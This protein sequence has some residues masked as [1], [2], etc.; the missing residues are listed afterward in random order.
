MHVCMVGVSLRHFSR[1]STR[2]RLTARRDPENVMAGVA[3]F[4]SAARKINR[5][6]ATAEGVRKFCALGKIARVKILTGG[7]RPPV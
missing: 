6:D 4:A 1:V 5:G 3:N 2:P 7:P